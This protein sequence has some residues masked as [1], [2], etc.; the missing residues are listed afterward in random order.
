LYKLFTAFLTYKPV[1]ISKSLNKTLFA[2]EATLYLLG[3]IS[4]LV[5]LFWSLKL[6][7]D[8]LNKPLTF[9]GGDGYVAL[10]WIKS[11]VENGSYLEN[12][13]LSAPFGQEFYDFPI[14][15]KFQFFLIKIIYIICQKQVFLTANIYYILVFPLITLTSIYVLRK[16]GISK[17]ICLLLGLLYSF[18]PY[19]F[20]RGFNHFFLSSYY[21]VPL[22]ILVSVWLNENS[23]V[24]NLKKG[25]FSSENRK[26]LISSFFL[27]IIGSSGVYY[28][29]FTFLLICFSFLY[30]LF[31]NRSLTKELFFVFLILSC[32][33]GCSFLANILP[34]ILYAVTQGKNLEVANRPIAD[35]E[36]YGLKIVHLLVPQYISQ[37]GLFN[38]LSERYIDASM[39][40][41]NENSC[42]SLGIVLSIGFIF[43]LIKSLLIVKNLK[44]KFLTILNYTASLNLYILL[45]STIGGFSSLFALIVS[46]QIRAWNRI[47]VFIAF[48]AVIAI[49]SLLQVVY[50]KF[51]QLGISRIFFYILCTI[52]FYIGILDQTSTEF[53]PDYDEYRTDFDN[54]RKFISAIE[55]SLD[56]NSMIFQ[57]PY[58]EY[59]E[60]SHLLEKEMKDYDHMRGYL[61][62]QKLKWSYGS[63]KGRE[64]SKWQKILATDSIEVLLKKLSLFDFDGI[65][66][67]RYGYKDNGFQVENELTKLLKT[68]PFQDGKKRLM[69]FD[70]QNFK[71][72]YVAQLDDKADLCKEIATHVTH[73]LIIST[74]GLYDLEKDNQGNWRW[75]NK[76]SEINIYNPDQQEQVFNMQMQIATGYPSLSTL[77]IYINDKNQGSRIKVSSTPVYYSV[78]LNIKPMSEVT[79]KFSSNTEQVVSPNDPRTMFFRI[80]NFTLSTPES[81]KCYLN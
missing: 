34:N 11:A 73:P 60:P 52:I 80:I 64:A 14:S 1:K 48:L 4:S 55:A 17:S 79:V 67:D 28:A 51:S 49:A 23:I 44:N 54:D 37:L 22:G 15:E 41:Q 45:I 30:R 18:L 7:L 33:L 13:F 69:F 42:A 76:T 29:F 57:I 20:L 2:P 74:P 31:L 19:H 3:L 39:P 27:V 9:S 26:L 68:S 75:S 78:Q 81:E 24:L 71:E 35:S 6:P 10:A 32:S 58:V 77:Y 63:V 72:D 59:P 65:Y 70:I 50:A 40:L 25:F 56:P 36:L 53:V 46:P 16:L 38:S 43:L 61:Y 8:V 62:S 12:P 66:I 5:T 21:G 47:S